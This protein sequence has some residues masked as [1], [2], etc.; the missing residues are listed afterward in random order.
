VFKETMELEYELISAYTPHKLV[1][2][3]AQKEAQENIQNWG[4]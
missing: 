3:E 4:K 2:A 1:S